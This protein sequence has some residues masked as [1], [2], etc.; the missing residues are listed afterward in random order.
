MIIIKPFFKVESYIVDVTVTYIGPVPTATQSF[1][2]LIPFCCPLMVHHDTV[3]CFILSESD[4]LCETV[5]CDNNKKYL[6]VILWSSYNKSHSKA[7]T[8]DKR[9]SKYN[10]ECIFKLYSTE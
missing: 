6:V 8:Y 2:L 3:F 1:C 7:L 5:L 4:L 9:D 10:T